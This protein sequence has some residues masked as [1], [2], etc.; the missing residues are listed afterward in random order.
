MTHE[1]IIS[2]GE[3]LVDNGINEFKMNLSIPF[4][5]E[6]VEVFAFNIS[7]SYSEG[8]INLVT[9]IVNELLNFPVNNKTW[10]KREI[11]NHYLACI[12][13][14]DYSHG[15]HGDDLFFKNQQHFKIFTEDDAYEKIKLK[16]IWFDVSYIGF[17]YFN[18]EYSCPWEK[19]HG[20]KIGIMNGEFD[21][22]Q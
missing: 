7:R 20:I 15:L 21:S 4:F 10:L 13:N 9:E 11:Y 2:S 5:E 1:A 14:M 18:L 12:S 8:E 19:E 6:E 16:M 17:R 3:F 22:M